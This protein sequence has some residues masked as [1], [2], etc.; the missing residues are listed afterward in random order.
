MWVGFLPIVWTVL[1][2]LPFLSASAVD[3]VA[4]QN[5]A[6]PVIAAL[7][8]FRTDSQSGGP[9]QKAAMAVDYKPATCAYCE[10]ETWCEI[11]VNGKAQCRACKV[12]RFFELVVYEPFGFKLQ[13]WTKKVLRDLYGTVRPESGLRQYRRAYISTGKQ[14]GKSFL[15]G[16]LPIYHL[17]MEQETQKEAYGLASARDQAGI[18]FKYAEMLVNASPVLKSQ[19]KVLPS[20]KRIVRRGDTKD[21]YAVLSADGEVQD[22]K[23]PSLLLEDE[24][25]RF[26]RKKAETVRTVLRKGMISRAPIVNGVETGEPLE[27]QITT[28]GD[29]F[30]SPTW[31][32]EY[33]HALAV[34]SGGII[35][36][37]YY[38]A[39]YQ[40]DPKRLED[41]KDYWKSREARVAANPS[42]ED[43]GGFLSDKEIE[44]DMLEVETRPEK[45]ADYIRLNLNVPYVSTGTPII[46]MPVWCAGGGPDNLREWPEYD[47]DLLIMKWGLKNKPC[48]LGVDLAWTTDMTGMSLVFPPESEAEKWK[49]LFFSWV[50]D[51]RVEPIARITRAPLVDWIRR[52]FVSTVPGVKMSLLEVEKKIRWAAK[53]FDVRE[54]C[55]DDW[56]G[57]IR[58]AEVLSEE[59]IT[60]VD[61]DQSIPILTAAT[62]E[63]LALYLAS[64][65]QHGNNPVMNWH[66]SCLSLI[67]DKNDNVKPSKPER[68]N[69]Q[70]RI[71][72]VS[73]TINAMVR[74]VVN[75]EKY[76]STIC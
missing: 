74:A 37:T 5:G 75:E 30:E 44:R 19:L 16:G 38:V 25:H 39:I 72:L 28:S 50:P 15:L 27:I 68:D 23:R 6:R 43:L 60:C 59:G 61:I 65:L 10:A 57:M 52:G 26:T 14:N 76:A 63:F 11:R 69:S 42:H 70:K 3:L 66:V 13:G 29:E 53:M 20:T 17:L 58:S 64:E 45:F 41:E 24:L 49:L 18:V 54:M 71:D 21:M 67:R 46:N 1:L 35:D 8:N 12:V 55:F 40:A 7:S 48:Y 62:K 36:P 56:G 2:C 47:V 4:G 9:N 31:F 34:K 33:Q 73:S 22:G 32:S 51:G